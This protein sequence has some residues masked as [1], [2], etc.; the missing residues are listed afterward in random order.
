MGVITKDNIPM[1]NLN[2]KTV[3]H[4]SFGEGNVVNISSDRKYIFISFENGE[5]Q[6]QFPGVFEKHLCFIDIDY[7]KEIEGI[8]HGHESHIKKEGKKQVSNRF[9]AS[10]YSEKAYD[11][12]NNFNCIERSIFNAL[13][14]LERLGTEGEDFSNLWKNYS[15]PKRRAAYVL[16]YLYAYTYEYLLM[17]ITIIKNSVLM[18]NIK[19]LSL[20]C[21][22]M[23][24]AW[25]LQESIAFCKAKIVGEYTG[26]DLEKD[27]ETDYF[28]KTTNIIKKEEMGISAGDY[29]LGLSELDYDVLI[30]PKSLADIVWGEPRTDF[31]KI[32]YALDEANFRKRSF[33]LCFSFVK[34]EKKEII[35]RAEEIVELIKKKGY[36]CSESIT[37]KNEDDAIDKKNSHVPFPSLRDDYKKRIYDAIGQWPINNR[38][39]ENN[40]IYFFTKVNA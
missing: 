18:D 33:C 34:N 5:K 28:P 19:V 30:F 35:E 2:G 9:S 25:A 16:K 24:D 8:L 3:R 12:K 14:D 26:V 37:V 22:V 36:E 31:D 7:Q 15:D 27:W 17:Y 4:K 11:L 1:M 23:T 13:Y 39:Y 10:N 29:L 21:G 32:I 40:R 20:G 6:F 38:T